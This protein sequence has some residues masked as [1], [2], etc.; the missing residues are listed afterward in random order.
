MPGKA[1]GDEPFAVQPPGG[2]FQ[3]LDT[4]L[5][6]FDQIVV[7]GDFFDAIWRCYRLAAAGT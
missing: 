5:V 4:A 2:F 6:V 1:Q 3:Q 7:G